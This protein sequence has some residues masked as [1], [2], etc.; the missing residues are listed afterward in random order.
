MGHVL[1]SVGQR[2]GW[3]AVWLAGCGDADSRVNEKHEHFNL[4][5]LRRSQDVPRF[6]ERG[7][8]QLDASEFRTDVEQAGGIAH[9]FAQ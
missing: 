4:H 8:V 6:W 5:V 1:L 3:L 9:A 2:A 7:I